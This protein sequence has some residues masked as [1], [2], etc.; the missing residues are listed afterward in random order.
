MD[1]RARALVERL[2]S[3]REQ[4]LRLFLTHRLPSA[5]DAEDAL[6]DVFVRLCRIDDVSHIANPTAFLFCVAQNIVRDFYRNRRRDSTA[7]ECGALLEQL[8]SR[9]P[10][11]ARLVFGDEW[12]RAYGAALQELTPKCRTV[13]VLCRMENKPHAEIA[14]E[15]GVSVKMV[16]KYMTQALLHLRQRLKEF[17]DG[18][19]E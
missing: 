8:P 2:F 12:L 1:D 3:E 7:G 15:L 16:E 9:D 10:S 6:Q 13:F 5:S 17:L 19:L 11:A 4:Q 18:G 14:A